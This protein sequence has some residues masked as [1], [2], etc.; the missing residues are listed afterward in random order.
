MKRETKN[1][2][3]YALAVAIALS[4]L[5][6]SKQLQSICFVF[7]KNVAWEEKETLWGQ[8]ARGDQKYLVLFIYVTYSPPFSQGLKADYAEWVNTAYIPV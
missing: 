2:V 6:E 1:S 4:S 3:G 5:L 7:L 8:Q